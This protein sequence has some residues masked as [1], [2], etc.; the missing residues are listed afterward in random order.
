MI[1]KAIMRAIFPE[2]RSSQI[3]SLPE[4]FSCSQFRS[5]LSKQTPELSQLLTAIIGK[6]VKVEG[7]VLLD[8]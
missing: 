6:T 5:P 7:N 8:G 3:N 1:L 4:W 2:S